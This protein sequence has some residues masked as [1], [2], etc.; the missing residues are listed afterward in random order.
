MTNEKLER[1]TWNISLS[2][3]L[4]VQNGSSEWKFG[5]EVWNGSLEWK[6]RMEV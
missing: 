5:M 6:F 1:F 2:F 3:D 4:E